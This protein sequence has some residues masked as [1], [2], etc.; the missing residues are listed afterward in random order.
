[1][2][3]LAIAALAVAVLMP[4]RASADFRTGNSWQASPRQAA[5][6][7]ISDRYWFSGD[8]L[9]AGHWLVTRINC[10]GDLDARYARNPRGYYHHLYCASALVGASGYFA[11]FQFWAT[12]SHSFRITN[13]QYVRA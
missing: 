11:R 3:G 9:G 5:A 2:P 4:S 7:M 12:G 6:Q 13:V 8:V 1:M 10:K